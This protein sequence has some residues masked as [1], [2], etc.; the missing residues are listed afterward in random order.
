[1][2][3]KRHFVIDTDPGT[4][5]A[6]AILI[7]LSCPDVEVKAL[8][9]VVGNTSAL[10]AARNGLRILQVAGRLDIPVYV[11]CTKALLGGVLDSI[12]IYNGTD[13]LG[14]VPDPN[15]PND[16]AIQPE[17]AVTALLRLSKEFNGNLSLVAIGPLTNLAM[18]IRLDPDFGTRLKECF[19]MGG[20]YRGV[21]NITASSEFNFYHD[22]EA[23][24][25]VLNQLNCP[26]TIVPWET[27]LAHSLPWDIY[28]KIRSVG[29]PKAEFL[30]SVEACFLRNN[31][32]SG[33]KDFMLADEF[34]MAIAIDRN[35]VKNSSTVYATVEVK[36]HQTCGQMVVDWNGIMGKRSNVTIVT[37]IDDALFRKMLL[38]S[39]DCKDETLL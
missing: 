5:D 38:S 34:V 36:G 39:V 6:R 9:T 18:A 11:G 29:T 10:Q 35:V 23:A 2:T 13:G 21:G 32:P 12:T 14:D 25:V 26:I 4:D 33:R 27:C 16:S 24:Y 8:T 31:L 3:S 37:S 15:A 28:Y 17:H 20:N 1:M 30:K 22:P 19:I 7:A